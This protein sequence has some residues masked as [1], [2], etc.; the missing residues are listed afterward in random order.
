MPDIPVYIV[1]VIHNGTVS[2][3][4]AERTGIRHESPQTIVLRSG[5]AIWYASHYDVTKA[6]LRDNLAA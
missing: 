5:N 6:S 2:K 1:D 4:V 3:R